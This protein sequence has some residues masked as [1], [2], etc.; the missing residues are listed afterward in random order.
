MG[1]KEEL[2]VQRVRG[3]GGTL[4]SQSIERKE[5]EKGLCY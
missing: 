2:V 4:I 1:K 3:T 5:V